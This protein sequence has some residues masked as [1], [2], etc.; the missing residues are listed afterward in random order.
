MSTESSPKAIIAAL[1][2][3]LG[4]AATKI[5]AWVL[6][7]ASSMLAEAIHS[8]ADSGNQGLLLLGSKRAKRAPTENHPFGF[9]R[10]RYIYAFIVS[11]V[12][13]TV[14]GLFALYEA[15]HK[16]DEVH[17]GHPND[18]LTS[19]WWWVPLVVL[20]A[21]IGMESLSFRTAIV[22]S[23]H[24][25]GDA[26]WR[27]FIRNA[28]APEL[29]VVLLED[30]AA[31][32]GLLFALIGVGLTL[33]TDNGY[34][35][36]AGTAAIGLLLVLVAVVL[37]VE[38]KSLLLGESAHEENQDL[39]ESAVLAE[40]SVLEILSLKTVHVGP[41]SILVACKISVSPTDSAKTVTD[42]I[43]SAEARIRAAVPEA[44]YIFIEPDILV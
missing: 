36:V 29:P 2:A 34:W 32:I 19:R 25:R 24:T 1:L 20:V 44:I 41:E 7:G 14:G 11:I 27:E 37:A 40:Q 31:L 12:L 42:T 8:I 13:F 35:D 3:N 22:E 18:L 17:A 33:L 39:I 16:Y 21:A 28:K 23:N 30:A 43:N 10:E 4:I 26:S 5:I 38:T 9:G 6:T 15:Y